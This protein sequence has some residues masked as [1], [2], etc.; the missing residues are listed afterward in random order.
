MS[1]LDGFSVWD[2]ARQ[3]CAENFTEKLLTL[4]DKNELETIGGMSRPYFTGTPLPVAA[5]YGNSAIVQICLENEANPNT[6]DSRGRTPLSHAMT[7]KGLGA[8]LSLLRHNAD[9]SIADRDGNTPLIYAIEND[10]PGLVM[11]LMEKGADPRVKNIGGEASLHF[12]A[13]KGHVGCMKILIENG[14]DLCATDW[15]GR[16]VLHIAAE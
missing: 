5:R 14:A 6:V 11:L 15:G 9:V 16:T 8:T 4:A 1:H 7:T 3:G 12:A 10:L 13:R 2:L